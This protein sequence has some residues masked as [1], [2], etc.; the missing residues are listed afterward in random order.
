M[1]L[2][3]IVVPNTKGQFIIPLALRKQ[4]QISPSTPMAIQI[5]GQHLVFKPIKAY[6]TADSEPS[7]YLAALKQTAGAWAKDD[8]PN[9]HSLELSASQ[10]RKSAW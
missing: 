6:V 10:K 3:P 4:L 8:S 2:Q 1:N 7:A 5:A 9:H